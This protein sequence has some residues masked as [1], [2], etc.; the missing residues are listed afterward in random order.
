[1][2]FA[3]D[4]RL[5][6]EAAGRPSYRR[7]GGDAHY[8]ATTLSEA[9]GGR[10]LPSLEVTIAFVRACGGDV[11]EWE[12]RWREVSIAVNARP[13]ISARADADS[14]YLGLRA[15]GPSDTN[16]FFG[17]ERVVTDML[18]K[19]ND[20]RLL[21]LF[22]ASGSGKS[23]VLGAGLAPLLAAAGREAVVC[24]PGA[25]PIEKCSALIAPLLG[26][27][28]EEMTADWRADE[29]GLRRA[30]LRRTADLVI[31]V[32]QFEEV[33]T[34]CS[35][36]DERSRFITGLLTATT[37]P[38]SRCRVVL[39]VRSDF[40]PHCST[41]PLLLEALPRAQVVV[42]PMN[43]NELRRVIVEPARFAQCSVESALVA[44]L[45]AHAHG[46]PGVLPLLSHVLLQVWARRSGNR[47]TVAAFQAAGGLEGA[48][49]RTADDVY[50]RLSAEHQDA[51]R[52]LFGRLVALGD[53]TEDTKRQVDVAE[54][55]RVPVEVVDAFTSARLLSRD[56]DRVEI[57]HEA[58]IRSWP[59][60]RN[61]IDADRDSLQVHRRLT[62]AANVWEEHDRD[63][64]AL[65]RGTRLAEARSLSQESLTRLEWEF[66]EGSVDLETAGHAARRRRA[67]RTRV[68]LNALT[69]LVVALAATVVYAVDTAREVTRQAREMALERNAVLSVC[70]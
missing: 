69:A 34:L 16:L 59:R 51:A 30:T 48:L 19:L 10:R 56:H 33:F 58:L 41:H 36:E 1:V 25:A 60:L 68:L 64:G 35:D 3:A 18:A 63:S 65:Y 54:L 22:G 43:A 28:P 57:T 12:H 62:E 37:T 26:N 39:G 2:E 8:S 20:Q 24:T 15:F 27:T 14:P 66:I 29:S 17:R 9:A 4:L 21:V 45:V 61:W 55:G 38:G 23:S 44:D 31:V 70:R 49:S 42:G 53:G 11:A 5:L 46:R 13:V 67:R 50:E 40:F 32:D 52:A 7:L 47:L 6:R